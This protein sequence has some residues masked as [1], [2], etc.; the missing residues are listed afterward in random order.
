LPPNK[1]HAGERDVDKKEKITRRVNIVGVSVFVLG[2]VV[3]LGTFYF[4]EGRSIRSHP[5]YEEVKSQVGPKFRA[6]SR[7][8]DKLERNLEVNSTEFREEARQEVAKSGAGSFRF[9]LHNFSQRDGEAVYCLVARHRENG[10]KAYFS[11]VP[12]QDDTWEG[13]VSYYHYVYAT[14][15]EPD[16]DGPC[17]KSVVGGDSR[18][19]PPALP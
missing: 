5:L 18:R 19:S 1:V 6:I 15:P 10:G 14:E 16:P 12:V 11:S 8:I 9:S 17:D 7:Y 4:L 13:R 3:V 2:L